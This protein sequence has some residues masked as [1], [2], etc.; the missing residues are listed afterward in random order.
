MVR[1]W[2]IHLRLL[3]TSGAARTKSLTTDSSSIYR[4]VPAYE[5][6]DH[7]FSAPGQSA[8]ATACCPV[9]A[10]PI[11]PGIHEKKRKGQHVGIP[12]NEVSSVLIITMR[13]TPA[14]IML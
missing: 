6:G 13:S 1:P 2:S 8:E 3:E 10:R 9:A 14:A 4:P 12:G 7:E 5:T 11:L